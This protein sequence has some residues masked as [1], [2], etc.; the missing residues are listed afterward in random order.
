MVLVV[1]EIELDS[2]NHAA[3]LP[4]D[5]LSALQGLISSWLPRKWCNTRTGVPDWPSTLCCQSGVAWQ[6]LPTLHDRPFV[7][8]PQEGSPDSPQQGVSPGLALV[9][10]V[11]ITVEWG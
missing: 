4:A 7:L 5:Q 1:L 9:A 3:R 11:L 2:V 8:L 6:N 10:S